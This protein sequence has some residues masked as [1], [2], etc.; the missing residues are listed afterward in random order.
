MQSAVNNQHQSAALQPSVNHDSNLQ[1]VA[2]A[3]L[4]QVEGGSAFVK[5][6]FATNKA[7][8]HQQLPR[9]PFKNLV[10]HPAHG[11]QY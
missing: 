9:E 5:N 7:Y 3:A 1:Q 6:Y 2:H 8:N 11:Q 4:S 10:M